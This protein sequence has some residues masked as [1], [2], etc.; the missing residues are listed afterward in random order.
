MEQDTPSLGALFGVF[1]RLGVTG[2]GGPAMIAVIRDLS[3]NRHRWVSEEGFRDGLVLAQ[4]IPG[5]TAMQ[6]AAYIGL[7]RRGVAGA[8]AAY[9]GL[10]LPAFFLMLGLS[11]FYARTQSIAWMVSL[12]HGLSVA[13]VAL[14]GFAAWTFARVSC[15][16]VRGA[17]VAGASAVALGLGVNPFLVIVGAAAAGMALY[18]DR[19]P[20][21]A[22]VPPGNALR[23]GLAQSLPLFT[24]L[25]LVMA[26]TWLYNPGLFDLARLMLGI[27][28]VS[29][30]GGFAALPLMYHQ[31]VD[32]AGQ[33]PGRM[34]MDGIALGQI[35]PGPISITSTFLGY[36][37]FGPVGAVVAT[38]AMFAPSFLILLTVAPSFAALKG[39]RRFFRASLGI[40]A[41]FVGLLAYVTWKFSLEATWGPAAVALLA[42]SLL[43]LWRRIDILY[44]V[45]FAAL[46]SLLLL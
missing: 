37:L 27:N 34:F 3:V 39:S 45:G 15:R 26:A 11:A 21:A 6:V 22:P 5:A 12:M 36:M 14:I 19:Q 40:A 16:E 13:V 42:V 30:S 20:D 9:L 46:Y 38:I 43:A 44:V 41:S 32:V 25:C 23:R 2:F 7:V 28:C 31:I 10:G 4:S 35:T 17:A 1:F 29:F 24:A 8:L 33:M 18:R